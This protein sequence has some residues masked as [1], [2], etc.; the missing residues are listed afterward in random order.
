MGLA[1]SAL[2]PVLQKARDRYLEI[3][4]GLEA[5]QLAWRLAPESNSIGFLIRHNAE[6][7]YRFCLMFFQRPLPPG[8]ALETIGPDV[9]DNGRYTDL[10][11]L[12]SFKDESY[13][14]LLQ[15]IKA[16]PADQW[17]LP[18]AAPIGEM[19]PRQALGRL[20]YHTGYHGGQI[21]LIRKYG[22]RP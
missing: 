17:D 19:T 16:L 22:N 21:G 7:E 13:T 4:Q 10:A 12:L 18:A 14:Y 15:A 3:L 11:A 6:V 5:E 8:V 20:I 2:F 9:R 1:Y